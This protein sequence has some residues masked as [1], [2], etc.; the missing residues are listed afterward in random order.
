MARDAPRNK[1]SERLNDSRTRSASSQRAFLTLVSIV[2]DTRGITRKG[3][4][5]AEA[6]RRKGSV[7]VAAGA[8]RTDPPTPRVRGRRR[9]DCSPGRRARATPSPRKDPRPASSLALARARAPPSPRRDPR[10]HPETRPRRRRTPRWGGR[11]E[12]LHLMAVGV[13]ALHHGVEGIAHRR[14]RRRGLRSGGRGD[15]RAGIC[16]RIG[17]GRRRGGERRLGGRGLDTGARSRRRAAVSVGVGNRRLERIHG[18]RR[19]GRRGWTRGFHRAPDFL[20]RICR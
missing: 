14:R 5:A 18:A 16:E 20:R 7:L 15:E 11:E 13:D 12:R 17:D 2:P 6:A 9:R 4:A 19:L 1:G 10:P 8:S 3:C